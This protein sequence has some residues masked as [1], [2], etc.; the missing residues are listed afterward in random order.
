[1]T[2]AVKRNNKQKDSPVHNSSHDEIDED[3]K[4]LDRDLEKKV[5]RIRCGCAVDDLQHWVD[6]MTEKHK[7]KIASSISNLS[8]YIYVIAIAVCI[9]TSIMGYIIVESGLSLFY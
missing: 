9:A 1:M 8:I 5:E 4:R 2:V 3:Q 6:D 7:P